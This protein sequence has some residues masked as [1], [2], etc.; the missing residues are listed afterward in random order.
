M[1]VVSKVK[2]RA[3]IDDTVEKLQVKMGSSE[4]SINTLSGGNQQKVVLGRW[5][6]SK[7]EV[8]ILDEPTRG[9]DVGAKAEIHKLMDTLVSRGISIL[10]IS[11]DLPEVMRMSDRILVMC[12]GHISGNF[13]PGEVDQD[14]VA[15]AAFPSSKSGDVDT[16]ERVKRTGIGK[17]VRF[18][19]G[20]IVAVLLAMVATMSL[21]R[22]DE[23]ASVK[24]IMDILTSASII[25]VA[26][27]GMTLVIITGGID[28]SIGSMLGLVGSVAGLSAINGFNPVL[29]LL[30]A[31]SMGVCL[32]SLNS[33]LSIVGRIH[34]IIVTLAGISIYRGIM[35]QITGGYE[36]NPLPD[37][38]RTLLDGCTLTVPKVLWCALGILMLNWLLLNR[39]I[40]GRGM[41]GVGNSAK[42]AELIGLSPW[43][44]RMAAFA[45]LGGLVGLASVMWGC[46]YGKVQSNTGL[47]FELQVIAATVIGGCS[48]KGGRGTALGTFL[49]AVLIVSIYNVLIILRIN[50]FWQNLFV[51]CLII[52]AA[53]IDTWLPKLTELWR[54][55]EATI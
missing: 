21:L 22:P 11:S 18:R 48:I 39:T 41:L 46:Y 37:G 42:A 53:L 2:E 31:I 8:L 34:P 16:K 38:Y 15:A 54:R 27:A 50:S 10:M 19:E 40:L 44:L 33:L 35:L 20:G 29:C 9:V 4:Q 23:F 47:G 17:L 55:R 49:G 12:E 52:A 36:V 1:G 28:I 5:L 30:L 3:V 7:P 6:A 13:D 43:K 32:G 51:G 14:K 26:A 24:N 25:S 45:V